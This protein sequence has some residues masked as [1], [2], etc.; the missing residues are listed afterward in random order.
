MSGI[1]GSRLNIKGSGLV[2]SLGTDGQ[3]FTS[4]GTGTGHVFE[5]AAGGAWN[6]ITT[7]TISSDS[8]VSFVHG[9]G[10][11]DFTTYEEYCFRFINI[12][13]SEYAKFQFNV[14]IDAGS[15]YNVAKTSSAISLY[16]KEDNSGTP[17]M[18][19][20]TALDLAN[21]TSA[22]HLMQNLGAENDEAGSGYLHLFG[23]ADTTFKKHYMSKCSLAEASDYQEG[24]DVWGFVNTTSAVD[25]IQFSSTAG[26]LDTGKIKL[27][28]IS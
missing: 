10:G 17:A 6:L 15:N 12:H 3:V 19:Y 18:T 21:T 5:D 9:T 1:V 2:G 8:T 24:N 4:S 13:L 11:V 27:Y 7:P 20:S 22:Q 14:S 25:A 16:H 26:T 23:L 28:G